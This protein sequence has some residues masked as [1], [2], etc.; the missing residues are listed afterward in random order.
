L[1][2]LYTMSEHEISRRD[3]INQSVLGQVSQV[4]AAELLGISDR[5]FRRLLKDYKKHGASALIS[6][7]RGKRSNNS[8]PEALKKRALKLVREKYCDFKPTLAAEKL[9]EKHNIKLS[10]ETLRLWMIEAGLW[11][12]RKRRTPR[13]HQTR[14]RRPRLGELIQADGSSHKWF[15]DRSGPCCLLGFIDD[16][17]GRIMHL[18]FAETESTESYFR[19]LKEYLERHGRPQSLYTDRFSVF[20]INGEKYG[21]KDRGMTQVGRALKELDIDLICANSPQAKGRI[22][23]L[24]G[25]LQDRLVKELRLLGLS[26]ME[27]ANQYLPQYIESHNAQFS[28]HAQHPDDAHKPL[29]AQHKLDD[30]FTYKEERTISKNLEV[31]YGPRLLQII[32]EK[33]TYAMRGAKVQVLETLTGEIKLVYQGKELSYKELLVKDRQG[34]ILNSKTLIGKEIPA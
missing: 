17:T 10:A 27:Q 3:V 25:T 15:E 24:F 23:R 4:K 26:T 5:H 22:E 9:R 1:E 21:Y 2:R 18:K 34:R 13:I 16:A 14:Q 32:S 7:R 28:V 33:P 11:E 30:V 19:A 6:K 8:L 12:A 31:S 29:L 20:R